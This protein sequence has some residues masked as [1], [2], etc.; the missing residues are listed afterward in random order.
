LLLTFAFEFALEPTFILAL[1]PELALEFE[2]AP[3]ITPAHCYC[4]CQLTPPSR[5]STCRQINEYTHFTAYQSI[6]EIASANQNRSH[7]ECLSHGFAMTVSF[8]LS[9]HERYPNATPAF[10]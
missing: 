2:L 1:A 8:F 4:Y 5:V 6:E 3:N 9:A 7:W 10:K